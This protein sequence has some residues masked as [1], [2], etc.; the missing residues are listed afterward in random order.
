M[1]AEARIAFFGAALSV[2]NELQTK[3][4]FAQASRDKDSV[5]WIGAISEDRSAARAFPDDGHINEDLVV[6][7][8]ISTGGRTVELA[9]GCAETAQ[10]FVKPDAGRRKGDGEIQEEATRLGSH[11]GQ[12]TCRPCQTLPAD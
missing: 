12:I 7:R 1:L 6:A 2:S 8:R 9:R 4:G 3:F 10:K 5:A 11:C